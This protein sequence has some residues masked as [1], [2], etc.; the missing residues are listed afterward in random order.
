MRL[1][2]EIN[3]ESLANEPH[4]GESLVVVVDYELDN[5]QSM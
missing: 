4:S 3:S 1:G 2:F 5:N